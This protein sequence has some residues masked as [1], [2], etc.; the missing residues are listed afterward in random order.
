MAANESHRVSLSRASTASANFWGASLGQVVADAR[1]GLARKAA[2]E[3]V[4]VLGWVNAVIGALK[5]H[6]GHADRGLRG[7]TLLQAVE[8]RVSRR[9]PQCGNGRNGEPPPQNLD[10]RRPP[11]CAPKFRR[12][13]SRSAKSF[14]TDGGT[15]LGGRQPARD[16][17]APSQGNTNTSGVAPAQAFPAIIALEMSWML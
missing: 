8:L 16:G 11:P 9:R 7:Q 10:C 4:G 2:G 1:E 3:T 6:A 5:H 13:I 12:P 15:T 17:P 14:S